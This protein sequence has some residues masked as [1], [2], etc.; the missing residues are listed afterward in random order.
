MQLLILDTFYQFI[1]I[2]LKTDPQKRSLSNITLYTKSLYIFFDKG[3]LFSAQ[4]YGIWFTF[5]F[6]LKEFYRQIIL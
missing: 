4:Q 1:L 3:F 2:L 5:F 6:M